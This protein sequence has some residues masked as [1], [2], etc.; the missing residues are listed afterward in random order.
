MNKAEIFIVALLVLLLV[1]WGYKE[2]VENKLSSRKPEIVQTLPAEMPG[3][4]SNAPDREDMPSAP[5]LE[6]L[7]PSFSVSESATVA[8]P[9]RVGEEVLVVLSNKSLQVMCSSFGAS[10]TGV[11]ISE[12]PSSKDKNSKP[13]FMDYSAM[14]ALSIGGDMTFSTNANFSVVRRTPDGAVFAFV[15]SSGVEMERQIVLKDEFVIEITDS[16]RNTADD[17]VKL[18][19]MAVALGKMGLAGGSKGMRGIVDIGID[20]FHGKHEEG[21]IH[22]ASPGSVAK[23]QSLFDLF[24]EPARRGGCSMFKP[25]MMEMMPFSVQYEKSGK[26][27]WIASKNKFFVQVLTPSEQGIGCW[28]QASRTVGDEET[29]SNSASWLAHAMVESVDAS[30]IFAEVLLEPAESFSRSFSYF[31]GPKKYVSLTQLGS[32]H[33]EIMEFGFWTPLSKLF[34]R[35]LNIIYS[36]IPNYGVA[37]ILMTLLVKLV[38]WPITRKSTESMKRMQKIQPLVAELREKYKDKPDKL[39]RET[40]ALYKEHKVNPMAGCL[41]LLFQI[42]V[43]IALFTMLRSAVELRFAP[44]LWIRDLSEQ[45]G[46][47]AGVLP[48][49]LNILP[50]IMTSMTVLQQKMT[51]Q[52]GDPQQQKM[53][54]LMPIIFLVMFYSMPSAL[55]LYWTTSQGAGIVAMMIGRLRS[56]EKLFANTK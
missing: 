46:L 30:L 2:S 47:L 25:R 18:S 55:V 43:F 21:T 14:P 24:Q 33:A 7:S 20:S 19:K 16:F 22:W 40:M 51:P 54:T 36:V 48:I 31:A 29:P 1:A 27:E 26:V 23:K 8:L 41:P 38:L 13:V 5:V 4:A 35:I 3:D 11:E 12:Y 32:S 9:A 50:L 34:L 28:M 10:I 45:E 37:I 49:P 42:P 56:G 52:A 53:M 6:T 15:A 17:P 44:F 39:N